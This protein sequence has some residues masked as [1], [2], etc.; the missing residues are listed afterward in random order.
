MV[1]ELV[2][3]HDHVARVFF[4]L[5]LQSAQ[6]RLVAAAVR[7]AEPALGAM[8]E[9][10][11]GQPF[12]DALAPGLVVAPEG[13]AAGVFEHMQQRFRMGDAL[14]VVIAPPDGR[15]HARH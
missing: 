5:R 6:H 9:R 4:D 8:F 2:Q 15:E 7:V 11:E 12:A 14:L 10:F 13:R 1:A 3:H